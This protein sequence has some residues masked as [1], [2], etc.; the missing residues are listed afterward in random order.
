MYFAGDIF[1]ITFIIL[2]NTSLGFECNAM[3]NFH[4][5]MNTVF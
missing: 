5:D 3:A 4:T 2:F 1:Y